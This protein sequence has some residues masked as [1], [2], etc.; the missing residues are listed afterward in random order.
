MYAQ[1][2]SLFWLMVMETKVWE[3]I[4]TPQ[5]KKKKSPDVLRGK[6]RSCSS[7]TGK[8]ISATTTAVADDELPLGSMYILI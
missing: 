6:K 7:K 8:M 3:K 1:V 5:K 2:D 4:Q